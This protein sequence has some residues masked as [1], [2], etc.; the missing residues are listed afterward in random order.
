MKFTIVT[1]GT[2][3]DTRPLAVLARGLMDAGHRVR[4]LA[5]ASTLGSAYA[6]GVPATGLSG[7]IRQDL[8]PGEVLSAL[9]GDPEGVDGTARA[10]ARVVNPLVEGWMRQVLAAAEGSDA[11]LPSALAAFVGL[12]VAE[13]LKVPAIGLGTIP[14]SPTSAFPSP[15]IRPGRVFRPFNRLSHKLVNE[16][17]WRGFAESTNAARRRVC[18]LPPRIRSWRDH[19]M[20]YGISPG[21]VPRPGDWP[22][23]ARICGQWVRPAGSWT[24]PPALDAFLSAGPPP[25]YIGFGSMAGI[26]PR[27]L[28]REVSRLARRYRIVFSPGWSGVDPAGL[29][30]SVFVI[31]EAPHDRLF[32]RMSV[33]VH[34]GGAGTSHSA[35]RAGVP[36]VVVP[37]AV[38]NAFW[39]DRLRRAGV[40]PA[41][42]DVAQLDADRLDAAIAAAGRPEMRE[43]AKALA[44]AMAAEDGVAAAVAAI[45]ALTGAGRHLPYRH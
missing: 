14:L 5:D 29:P 22:D 30:E 40:A 38:D 21:L 24:P 28:T 39:A 27:L 2:E 45:E 43:R 13:C 33:V 36:S 9:V 41:P 12:S 7:D 18:G 8:Q 26:N 37:F 3:G 25:V 31:G 35:V 6:L 23:T 17:F 11:I 32:P 16:R 20:L 19:P 44:A 34:H 1:Y 10:A 15:F 42:V 4:L